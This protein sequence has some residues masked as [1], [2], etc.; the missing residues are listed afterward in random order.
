MDACESPL[1]RQNRKA[2]DDDETDPNDPD[3]AK[4]EPPDGL[5]AAVR[6][7]NGVWIVGFGL[8][9]ADRRLYDGFLELSGSRPC[10]WGPEWIPRPWVTDWLNESGI[11][12]PEER[13]EARWCM[14]QLDGAELRMLAKERE[15]AREMDEARRGARG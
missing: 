9:A 11:V 3:N 5:E 4:P 10:G 6:R 14:R 1:A 8:S 12:D 15:I 2:E 7:E 13:D